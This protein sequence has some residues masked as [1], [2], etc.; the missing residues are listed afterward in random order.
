MSEERVGYV[1]VS[2]EEQN[3]ARQEVLMEQLEADKVFIDEISGKNTDRMQLKEMLEYVRKGDT[4]IVESIGRFARNTKDLL[5]LTDILNSKG[6]QFISQKERIDTSTPA[7]EFM[8]TVFAAI[9]QLE[10]QNIL[11][12]QAEGIAIAKAEGKY[13]GRKPKELPDFLE[14]YE[15]WKKKR[16]SAAGASRALNV[17]RSTFYRKVKEYEDSMIIDFG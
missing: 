14:V 12:R 13:K 7:G 15:D 16:V 11:L 9:A 1:R 10:R 4:V 3:T 17:S 2:T 6:V 8:L 5:E